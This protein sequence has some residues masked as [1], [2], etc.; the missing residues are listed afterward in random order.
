MISQPNTELQLPRLVN[1]RCTL[2]VKLLSC[3][4]YGVLKLEEPT[5]TEPT[6]SAVDI[7]I[8]WS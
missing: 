6:I 5:I 7:A 4:G 3:V 1:P 8:F 2:D